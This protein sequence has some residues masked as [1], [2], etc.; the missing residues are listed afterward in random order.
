VA[1][2]LA[3]T[4]AMFDIKLFDVKQLALNHGAGKLFGF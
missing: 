3:A 1:I 2:I 4:N